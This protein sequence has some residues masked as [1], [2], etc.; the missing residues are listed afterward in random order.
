MA[1]TDDDRYTRLR[2]AKPRRPPDERIVWSGL[3]FG[4]CLAY[5]LARSCD[6]PLLYKGRDF[7]HTDVQSP[8]AE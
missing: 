8:I 5:A 2:P 3:N 6:E 7:S 4:D 1:R